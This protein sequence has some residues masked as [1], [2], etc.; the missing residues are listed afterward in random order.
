MKFLTE[1][2]FKIMVLNKWCKQFSIL[3][4]GLFVVSCEKDDS[5]TKGINQQSIE[6]GTHQLATYSQINNTKYLV[7]FESGLGNGHSVWFDSHIVDEIQDKTDVLLYDRA[8]Y[9]NSELG[10]GP[11]H[12]ERLSFEFEQVVEPYL[13]NRKLI[14]VCHSLG[15]LIARDYTLNHPEHVA[16]LVFVDPTHE[17]YNNPGQEG[18]DILYNVLVE[19]F[20]TEHG[21]PM[22]MREILE[23]IEYAK[24]LPDLPNIPVRVLTSMMLDPNNILAD[25]INGGSRESWYNAHKELGEGISDFIHIKT[26]KSGHYIMNTEPELIINQIDDLL[27]K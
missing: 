20:G 18:E 1:K 8:G 16:G 14:I 10:P 3:L 23:D 7:V 12:I 22:E 27:M 5:L 11:R 6:L 24:T 9:E 13:K 26:E 19:S 15:G 17:S 2:Q 25:E 21:A 4:I